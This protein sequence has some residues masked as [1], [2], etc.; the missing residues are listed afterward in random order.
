MASLLIGV[1]ILLVSIGSMLYVMRNGLRQGATARRVQAG[2][3]AQATEDLLE[4]LSVHPHV[5]A[6]YDADD[7]GVGR[8]LGLT[9]HRYRY[10]GDDIDPAVYD[11]VR[12][13]RQVW[14]RAGQSYKMILG[15]GLGMRRMRMVTVL[16]VA[17][18]AF[19][20]TA[21]D[22]RLVGDGVPAPVADGLAGMGASAD[23]WHD[24]RVVAGPD[25]IVVNRGYARDF[26]GG[27]PYDLWLV[28]RIADALAAPALAPVELGREWNA[29][30]DLGEWAPSLRDALAQV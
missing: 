14:I 11:G 20:L 3:M 29:P 13:G 18:P 30:Y 26:S 22:G 21:V 25:G 16:R 12:A 23:V 6:D 9:Y 15:P 2:G 8:R 27:W 28:E 1:P 7:E 4:S 24:L 19:E 5:D 17:T 10:L